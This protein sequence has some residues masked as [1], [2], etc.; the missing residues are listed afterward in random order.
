[1]KFN[2]NKIIIIIGII[3]IIIL[4]VILLK[5]RNDNDI[6]IINE[7]T[8]IINSN[9]EKLTK[10]IKSF[11]DKRENIYTN[12]FDEI[13]YDDLLENIN[14]FKSY[15]N[16]YKDILLD[17]KKA[18]DN[19]DNSCSDTYFTDKSITNKCLNSKTKYIKTNNYYVIDVERLNEII[20]IYNEWAI[21]NEKELLKKIDNNIGYIEE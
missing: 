13:Y 17:I 2:K 9:Y 11:S 19:I 16:E 15:F 7:K 3:T 6:K 5:L 20:D 12:V 4:L 1:M 14:L 18:F 21:D 8:T 10:D